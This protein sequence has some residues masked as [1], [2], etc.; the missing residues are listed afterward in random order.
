MYLLIRC[1][2]G[3]TIC[4]HHLCS[5]LSKYSRNSFCIFRCLHICWVSGGS[6]RVVVFITLSRNQ[7]FRW[8]DVHC[9]LYS[10][11]NVLYTVQFTVYSE[12]ADFLCIYY[13]VVCHMALG[14]IAKNSRFIWFLIDTFWTVIDPTYG[15]DA[16]TAISSCVHNFSFPFFPLL[17]SFDAAVQI[18]YTV[19]FSPQHSIVTWLI[20]LHM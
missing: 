9:I 6:N 19:S 15:A 4:S 14:V 7:F 1:V 3:V 18:F 16:D 5:L 2:L 17:V 12:H 13:G 8:L 20:T 10:N 11:D